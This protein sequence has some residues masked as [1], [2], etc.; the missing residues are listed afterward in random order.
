[1]S[2]ILIL[3]SYY[4]G[5]ATANG[6]CARN[7]VKQLKQDGHDVYVVCYNN[8]DLSEE[9]V[10]T[11]EKPIHNIKRNLIAKVYGRL[12]AT[13][14]VTLDHTL[15]NEYQR[16]TLKLCSEKKIDIVI[17]MF[18]P[19]EAVSILAIIK[20]NFHAIRTV[21]YEL[22]SV[23]D[24]IF[25]GSKYQKLV[26]WVIER[27]CSKQYSSVDAIIVMYSHEEYWRKTFGKKYN[28]KLMLADIPVLLKKI[29]PPVDKNIETPVSF[30]YGG[31]MEQAY[32]SPDYLLKIFESYLKIEK[33]TLHFFSKGDC[34]EQIAKIAKRVGCIY[35][36]GYISQENFDKAIAKMDIL[37][38]LGNRYSRSVPSKLITYFTY[39]KPIVH[40]SLQKDDVCVQYLEKYPLG[41]VLREWDPIE[42]NTRK[43]YEFVQ[44]ARGRKV[45]FSEVESVFPMNTPAYSARLIIDVI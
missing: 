32:R 8:E 33:A 10:Y 11:I 40:F 34:E 30:L 5:K 29:L 31:L 21:I 7:I 20:K 36:N 12:K 27:W 13:V 19:F 6:I 25:S 26:N 16:I 23:G 14:S 35:Q 18:F 24:G 41:L 45:D 22:D 44:K 37:I 4:L 39:G 43:L 28:K 3:S 38:S 42:E 17:G 15:V 2:R 9:N 1:M